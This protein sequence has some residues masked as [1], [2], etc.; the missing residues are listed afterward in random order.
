MRTIPLVTLEQLQAASTDEALIVFVTVSHEAIEAPIRLVLDHADYLRDGAL[1]RAA[2]FRLDL[3]NDDERPPRARF[4]F[5]AVNREALTR[6]AAVSAPA[7]VDCEILAAAS[8]DLGV[9]PRQEKPGAIPIYAA[10]HL[11]L[12]DVSLDAAQ[13]SGAL[14][15]W[16]YRQEL[17]PNVLATQALTPGLWP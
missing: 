11:F 2:P 3:V 16:D 6:L 5:P 7:R 12:T 1:Y 8:F 17:W 14:R 9:N 4:S 15:G 10:R 13:C